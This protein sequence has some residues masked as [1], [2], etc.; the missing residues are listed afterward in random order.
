MARLTAVRFPLASASATIGKSRTEMELVI[1][2][3]KR[4]RGRLMPVSTPYTPRASVLFRPW[5]IRRLGI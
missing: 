4:M 3:G 5:A 1:A 2:E